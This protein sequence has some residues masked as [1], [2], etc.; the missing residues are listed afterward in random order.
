MIKIGLGTEIVMPYSVE[1]KIKPRDRVKASE[2]VI[3]TVK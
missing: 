3:E 2:S 1:I